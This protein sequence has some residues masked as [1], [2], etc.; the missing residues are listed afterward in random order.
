MN[1]TKHLKLIALLLSFLVLI[2]SCTVYQKT[3]STVDE[4]V[5]SKK[6]VKVVTQ[7][8]E[9]YQFNRLEIENNN[10]YG[11]S[12][13][14]SSTAEKLSDQIVE[15]VDKRTVRILL[16]DIQESSIFLP[17]TALND[18]AGLGVFAGVINAV[19]GLLAIG[20]VL[21]GGI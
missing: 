6:Q 11:V 13:M 18:V 5:K 2:Q 17:N 19:F 9:S 16:N 3:P 10:I 1:N 14:K 7:T 8:K 21:G 4:A 12:S 20:F 15:K